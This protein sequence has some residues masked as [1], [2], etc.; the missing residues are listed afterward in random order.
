MN[1]TINTLNINKNLNISNYTV[2][3]QYLRRINTQRY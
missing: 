3:T 2:N 1:N